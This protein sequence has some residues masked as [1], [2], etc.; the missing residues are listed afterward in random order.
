MSL[1]LISRK[2]AQGKR[3]M[4]K[5]PSARLQSRFELFKMTCKPAFGDLSERYGWDQYPSGTQDKPESSP[6]NG[7]QSWLCRSVSSFA[8]PALQ[9]LGTK[10][11]GI[12]LNGGA[13]VS[14]HSV[15]IAAPKKTNPNVLS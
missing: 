11:N 3:A 5:L 14:D 7:V 15:M 4:L 10:L 13:G 8:K 1:P 6:L 9:R 12:D 2:F